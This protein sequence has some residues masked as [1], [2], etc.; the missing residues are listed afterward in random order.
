MKIKEVFR[1]I[2]QKIDKM[3]ED[4]ELFVLKLYSKNYKE[5]DEYFELFIKEFN[6]I[7]K[8]KTN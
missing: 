7:K 6:K 1:K 4:I 5:A 3:I 8:E 2:K